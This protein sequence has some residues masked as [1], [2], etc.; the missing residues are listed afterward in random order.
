MGQGEKLKDFR[1]PDSPGREGG[2]KKRDNGM[3]SWVR[4]KRGGEKRA[5]KGGN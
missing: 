1:Q 3:V 2:R 5:E 4:G